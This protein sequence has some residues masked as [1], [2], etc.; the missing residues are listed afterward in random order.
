MNH[1]NK[2][3]N[4]NI[5]E[6]MHK[7]LEKNIEELSL[8]QK[9]QLTSVKSNS[10]KDLSAGITHEI[11]TPL[12]YIKGNLELMRFDIEDLEEGETKKR[13]IENIET[14]SDG[15]NKIS[16]TIESIK[17]V[18]EQS[19]ETS[20][21]VNIYDTLVTALIFTFNRTK[22][23][24]KI[25]LNGELFDIN[26]N[27]YKKSLYFNARVQK[28]RIEQVW[29]IIINNALDE[30]VKIEDYEKRILN[31]NIAIEEGKVVV[32]FIDNAGGIK[33]KEIKNIFES[34]SGNKQKGGI[35]IG[36]SVAK[37]IVEENLGTIIATNTSQGAKFRIELQAEGIVC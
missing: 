17:Q 13:I 26:K 20:R 3:L 31:I 10:I 21:S 25:Y 8:L 37:K 15:V 29:M 2:E 4:K 23:I 14:I 12:T 6:E 18:S 19:S 11:N 34:F 28:K 1:L 27:N 33:E 32:D 16:N 5:E 24:S 9:E 35:G 30:L 22:Q 7:K 36:L